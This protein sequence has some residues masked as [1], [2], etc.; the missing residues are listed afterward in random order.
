[1]KKD[2]RTTMLR[3]MAMALALRRPKTSGM[4]S[5]VAKPK[6]IMNRPNS[7]EPDK[8]QVFSCR[9]FSSFPSPRLLPMMTPVVL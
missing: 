2:M 4:I 1:M 5:V 7:A 9:A 3:Q 6:S 8:S